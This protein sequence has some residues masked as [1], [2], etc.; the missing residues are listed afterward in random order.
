MAQK[1][2]FSQEKYKTR[3]RLSH[4]QSPFGVCQRF[5]VIMIY[6]VQQEAYTFPSFLP[7]SKSKY[8]KSE[9]QSHRHLTFKLMNEL[10]IK[11]IISL[12]Y[13]YKSNKCFTLIA[14][15]DLNMY[16]V[17]FGHSNVWYFV[18]LGYTYCMLKQY[19]QYLTQT[20]LSQTNWLHMV[21][22]SKKS[23]N[24][25]CCLTA[26]APNAL[27]QKPFMLVGFFTCELKTISTQGLVHNPFSMQ[28]PRC[29]IVS[30]TKKLKF[31]YCGPPL[32]ALYKNTFLLVY[33]VKS[34]IDIPLNYLGTTCFVAWLHGTT[35]PGK[36]RG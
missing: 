13:I 11:I 20:R 34:T 24:F 35:Q 1:N 17:I 19:L 26:H 12:E 9:D 5:I 14:P 15:N 16:L 25:V 3:S 32:P 29:P 21:L 36:N 28:I 2:L 30:S 7:F 31:R 22:Q 8:T 23:L 33:D 10:I 6:T 4:S 18:I 27:L